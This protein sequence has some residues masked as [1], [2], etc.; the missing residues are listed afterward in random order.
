[1]ERDGAALT[2]PGLAGRESLED[3]ILGPTFRVIPMDTS[4]MGVGNAPSSVGKA[5][6]AW[7][8]DITNAPR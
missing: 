3:G 4:S 5:V 2:S 7:E 8:E 6:R 1:M